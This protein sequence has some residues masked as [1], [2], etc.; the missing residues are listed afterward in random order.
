MTEKEV[1]GELKKDGTDQLLKDLQKRGVD[2]EMNAD[3]EKRL[4]KAKATDQVVQAVT[5]AGPKERAAAAQTTA[6]ASGALLL[7][8]EEQ[9]EFTAL[10]TELDPD[11]AISLAEAYV[12]K[13]PKSNG[14]SFVYAFEA[15]AYQ[16]KANDAEMKADAA[17]TT[18]M[19]TKVVE[20]L[21]KS[22]ELKK[23][24]PMSLLMACSIIPTPQ[25]IKAHQ[26]DEEKQL[27]QAEAY[28]NDATKA[29]G[30]LKKPEKEQDADFAR[31]KAGYVAGIHANL[32]MIHL[33]RATLALMG[34]DKEELAKAEQEYRQAVSL[35]DRP[36]PSS[37]Y[38]LGEACRLQGKW[39]E[40][41][42]AFTK[43]SELGQ[44]A[45]KQYA[46]QQID[47][48]KKLKSQAAPKP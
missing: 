5:S 20:Y 21:E 2:F 28:C 37:Y 38:R 41:I 32:G 43:A 8:A 23:D 1:I 47:L 9:S 34:L 30:D 44:G 29:V 27:T 26:A 24:N 22:L 46:E 45:V 10:Q 16:M 33:D 19:I 11:K 18:K 35:T 13:Y 3:I 40:A 17:E 12:Q 7:T 14:L 4:R 25:Y 36:D 31:R 39:D 42:A 15:G 6:M 48:V